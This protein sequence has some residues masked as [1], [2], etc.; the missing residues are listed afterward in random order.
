MLVFGAAAILV[1]GCASGSATRNPPTAGSEPLAVREGSAP[2]VPALVNGEPIGWDELRSTLAEA[3]GAN[4]VSEI[5]LERVLEQEMGRRGLT[6]APD[7]VDKELEYLLAEIGTPGADARTML[8]QVRA[9]RGLGETRFA[10]LLR[11][12]AMLRAL[13][14]E[15]VS[16]ETREVDLAER[17]RYGE[18][19][20]SLV[21][22]TPTEREASDLRGQILTAQGDIR[23]AFM[24]RAAEHSIDASASRGG[25]LGVVSPV[26]PAYPEALR[27]AIERTPPGGLT[28]ILAIDAGFAFAMVTEI[29]PGE[30]SPPGE[31]DRIERELRRRKERLE[32]D[33]IATRLMDQAKITVLDRG[34]SWSWDAARSPQ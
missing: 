9:Q 29:V 4:A 26:D 31:R 6:L 3:G 28:P 30:N 11:R 13:A 22:V 5:A 18:R 25:Q 12:S 33:R 15:T 1:S 27:G 19:R 32:M 24:A 8:D 7:A 16:V 21:I 14:Q 10:R 2:R 20:R 17:I 34:L 23:D